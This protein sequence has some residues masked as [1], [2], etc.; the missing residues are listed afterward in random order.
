MK[1]RKRYDAELKKE[2]AKLYIN[3]RREATSLATELGVQVNTIY[4]W[5]EQY[6]AD[7]NNA[8]TRS[9]NMKPDEEELIRAKRRVRESEEE[10]EI[11]IKAAAY[12]AKNST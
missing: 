2:I 1:Q 3:G 6:R 12:F 5:G 10:V 11:L 4:M 7:P 9:G 8:F